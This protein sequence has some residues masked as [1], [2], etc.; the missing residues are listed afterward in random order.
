MAHSAWYHITQAAVRL[1]GTKAQSLQGID[2]CFEVWSSV[3]ATSASP[4]KWAQSAGPC[5]ECRWGHGND[6]HEAHSR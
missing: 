5:Q 2:S 4:V 6:I 3:R 1:P